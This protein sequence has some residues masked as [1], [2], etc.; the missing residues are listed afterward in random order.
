MPAR[1][2]SVRTGFAQPVGTKP[3]FGFRRAP[4][5]NLHPAL[6]QQTGGGIFFSRFGQK[7]LFR[8]FGR[9]VEFDLQQAIGESLPVVALQ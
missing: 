4:E 3:G 6:T 1:F 9:G 5:L 8:R 2:T 7:V